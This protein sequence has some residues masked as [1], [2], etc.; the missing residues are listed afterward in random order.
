MSFQLGVHRFYRELVPG[1]RYVFIGNNL[2]EVIGLF[3]PKVIPV[4]VYEVKSEDEV[5]HSNRKGFLQFMCIRITFETALCI[6]NSDVAS[7]ILL[8]IIP[9]TD[10][11]FSKKHATMNA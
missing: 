2:Y 1:H 3:F 10:P 9:L 11:S 7:L 8:A 4:P 6:G 5:K